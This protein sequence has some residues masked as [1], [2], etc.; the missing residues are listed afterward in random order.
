VNRTLRIYYNIVRISGKNYIYIVAQQYICISRKNYIYF[1]TGTVI[2]I[3]AKQLK[4]WQSV[5]LESS[6]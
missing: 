2:Y 1:L 6:Y 4:Q 5:S 3:V